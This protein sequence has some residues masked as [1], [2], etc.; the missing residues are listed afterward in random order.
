MGFLAMAFPVLPGQT[1]AWRDWMGSIREGGARHAEFAASRRELGVRERTFLQQT[2]QGDL[3][4]VTL[5]GDDPLGAM[6]AFFASDDEFARWF[7][8]NV[9]QFHGVDLS[10]GMPGPPPELIVDSGAR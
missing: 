10:Q 2:P 9:R 3:V 8:A 1:Q 4:I 5:E 7:L 6:A